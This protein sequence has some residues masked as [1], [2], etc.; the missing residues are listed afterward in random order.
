[1]ANPAR[2]RYHD[3]AQ[4]MLAAERSLYGG[5]HHEALAAALGGR[6]LLS[7]PAPLPD[8]RLSQPVET[9]EQAAAFL[10]EQ[11]GVLGLDA[12]AWTPQRV[13]PGNGVTVLEFAAHQPLAVGRAVADVYGGLSLAFDPA[14]QLVFRSL[15]AI[16]EGTRQAERAGIAGTRIASGLFSDG[17]PAEARL[18]GGRLE[19]LPVFLD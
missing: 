10:A 8:V 6:D 9:T 11:A 3:V 13:T 1:M 19:R 14:G 4:A 16:S 12:A 2:A 18:S 5:L 7:Q 15:D 17:L